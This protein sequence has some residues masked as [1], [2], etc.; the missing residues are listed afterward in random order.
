L[1]RHY[2]TVEGPDDP[3]YPHLLRGFIISQQSR[4][5]AM[6]W[7]MLFT[8]NE[9]GLTPTAYLAGCQQF[10]SAFSAGAP[11]PQTVVVSGHI[12]TPRGFALVNRYHLRVSS[13]AHARPREAGMALLLDCAAPVKSADELL[14]NLLSVFEDR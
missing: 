9:F 3:R 5:F 6:L 1:A 14:P 10:L 12:V 7:D 13:A 8:Q 11:T 2:L 4:E